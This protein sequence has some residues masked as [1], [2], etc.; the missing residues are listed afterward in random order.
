MTPSFAI[1][2]H[3]WSI[4]FRPLLAPQPIAMNDNLRSVAALP[5][6]G[7]GRREPVECGGPTHALRA[8]AFLLRHAGTIAR[9]I[10]DFSR[11]LKVP[12]NLSLLPFVDHSREPS[13]GIFNA[14]VIPPVLSSAPLLH[15]S[16]MQQGVSDYAEIASGE[17]RN[18]VR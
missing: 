3:G 18:V 2:S 9:R 17:V 12:G 7:N 16:N 6:P 14:L 5:S 13:N 11:R 10:F 4:R 1:Y 8:P 15:E